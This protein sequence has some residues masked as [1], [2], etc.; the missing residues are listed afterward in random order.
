MLQK[1][2]VPTPHF[3]KPF[4]LPDILTCNVPLSSSIT[5]SSHSTQ[6]SPNIIPHVIHCGNISS[7]TMS[8]L[9][10]PKPFQLRVIIGGP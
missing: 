1:P 4:K 10:P 6:C 5:T 9:R 8:S 3:A 2:T 7:S